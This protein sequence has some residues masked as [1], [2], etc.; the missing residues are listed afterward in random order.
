MYNSQ[1]YRDIIFLDYYL[2]KPHAFAA[3]YLLDKPKY[4]IS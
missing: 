1:L 3:I 2:S 4:M